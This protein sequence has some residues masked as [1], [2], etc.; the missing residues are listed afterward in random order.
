MDVPISLSTILHM[1]LNCNKAITTRLLMPCL[2]VTILPSLS[3]ITIVSIA[4]LRGSFKTKWKGDFVYLVIIQDVC[5]VLLLLLQS[6][7]GVVQ[8]CLKVLQLTGEQNL[9]RT[10]LTLC[11]DLLAEDDLMRK[12]RNTPLVKNK[13]NF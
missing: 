12:S 9:S 7:Q 10:G 13:Y 2:C 11:S 6:L 5:W 8:L 3:I 4:A 1:G